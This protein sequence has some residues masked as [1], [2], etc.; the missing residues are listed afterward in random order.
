MTAVRRLIAQRHLAVLICA[1]ALA[2]RLL[3]PAG[4]MIGGHGSRLAIEPCS[5]LASMPMTM[6]ET[7]PGVGPGMGGDIPDHGG[8]D[9]GQKDHGGRAE[10]PCAF[11]GLSAASLAAADPVRLA[12]LVAFVMAVRLRPAAPPAAA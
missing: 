8:K 2:L 12:A 5:G 6:S 7:G 1:A 4:Y 10:M 11:S 3:V 9:H